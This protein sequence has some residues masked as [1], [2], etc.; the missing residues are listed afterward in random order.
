MRERA[1]SGLHVLLAVA[2][3]A[4][5]PAGIFHLTSGRY[6]QAVIAL[7]CAT[8]G[9]YLLGAY[10]LPSGAA[11]SRRKITALDAAFGPGEIQAVEML[12]ACPLGYRMGQAW[13]VAAGGR[14]DSPLCWPAIE[15]VQPLL[16]GLPG[17]A[18]RTAGCQCPIGYSSV[19]FTIRSPRAVARAAV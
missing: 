15:A 2:V 3:V 11:K 7:G 17:T 9:A 6:A 8:I 5:I 18:G 4:A 1:T 14:L 13:N 16:A 19:V 12:G 10:W